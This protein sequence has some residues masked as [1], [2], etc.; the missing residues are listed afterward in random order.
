MQGMTQRRTDFPVVANPEPET[1]ETWRDLIA[2]FPDRSKLVEALHKQNAHFTAPRVS[3]WVHRNTF[4]DWGFSALIAAAKQLKVP[5][6]TTERLSRA[7]QASRDA[8][9]KAREAA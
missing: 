9:A 2:L 7:A 3:L 1:G 4:P 6:I 5:G 8:R